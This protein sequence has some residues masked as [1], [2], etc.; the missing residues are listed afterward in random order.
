MSQSQT[1]THTTQKKTKLPIYNY[2]VCQVYLAENHP[3]TGKM[4]RLLASRLGT[5]MTDR[6]T[7]KGPG[8]KPVGIIKTISFMKQM[9]MTL[10]RC[11]WACSSLNNQNEIRET[12][13]LIAKLIKTLLQSY[14]NDNDLPVCCVKCRTNGFF[15]LIKCFPSVQSLWV[16]YKL[17]Y[18][19]HSHW[20]SPKSARTFPNILMT[21]S[22]DVVTTW[23]CTKKNLMCFQAWYVH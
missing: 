11:I 5:R 4:V 16:T 9:E 18:H 21:N 8:T 1:H 22:F 6:T 15:F 10:T 14:S 17:E 19:P 7:P 13:P 12:L 3:D 23:L 2:S 20:I